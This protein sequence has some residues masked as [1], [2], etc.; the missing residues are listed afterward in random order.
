MHN[1]LIINARSYET[2]V[3]LVENG[4]VI[5]FYCERIAESELLGNIYR[6][7]V[8]RVL[9]G[10]QA[11]FIDIGIERT[12]FLYVSDVRK[13][14]L[15][16]DQ[17]MLNDEESDDIPDF[18]ES[19]SAQRGRAESP[20]YH[21]EEL[22]RE[23][24]HLMVQVSKEPIG[25]KGARLTSHISIP[26]RFLVLMP[27]VDHIGV[28]R[29]IEDREKKER[30]K[31][32]VREIRP[33]GCGFIIRTASEDVSENALKSEMDFLLKVWSGI[34]EKMESR[35]NPGLLHRDLRI[36]L[37]AVRDLFTKEVERLI[38]DS[39]EEYHRI[40]EFVD[41]FAP[42]LRNSIEYYND[43]EPIFEAFGIENIIS[44]ALENK[45]PLKSGGHI[46]IERT[47]ALTVIDVNTGRFVGKKNLEETL[48]QTNLEA[49]R[50]IAKQLRFRNIG[51]I[52]VIDFISMDERSNG[53]KVYL[54]LKD[55]LAR[56]RTRTNIL[57]MS[58][59][60]LIE[61]TRKR[62]RP[63]L[64]RLMTEPCF[65]CEGKGNLK[66]RTAI[67][68]EIFRELEREDVISDKEVNVLVA[69]NPLIARTL[70]EEEQQSLK[71]LEK[72]LNKR[73]A[74]VSKEGFQ[75]ERYEISF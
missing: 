41:S 59:L 66:S 26:G 28:S 18:L 12:A 23:G 40:I 10:M 37:R 74:I 55:T 14:I 16:F 4:T 21:I 43:P 8:I 6:G 19:E 61:M 69:V 1:E 25:D 52:I 35:S 7:K 5:E 11:A 15:D 45:I 54:A 65:Y 30:L 33:A 34:Q 53:E 70:R 64:N 58:E 71:T 62:T 63:S 75:L 60:G 20:H 57:P 67:C 17:I 27:T 42:Q 2:R 38:I 22:L 56:D 51:G 31:D 3:A 29:R 32:M 73:I 48:L 44:K 47:E 36:S 13:D 72:R 24:Q 39:R 46:V 68:H 9:P 50:E 49:A